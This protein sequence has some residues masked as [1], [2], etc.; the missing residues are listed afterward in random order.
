MIKIRAKNWAMN[1]RGYSHTREVQHALAAAA[2]VV[3]LMVGVSTGAA[4]FVMADALDKVKAS[5]THRA[6]CHVRDAVRHVEKERRKWE[7]G[8]LYPLGMRWFSVADMD[9]TQRAKYSATMTDREFFDLWLSL[10]APMYDK[11]RP[12]QTSLTHKYARSMA[13]HGVVE[14]EVCGQMMMAA[15]CL[16]VA[17]RVWQQSI[18]D[19]ETT[20]GLPRAELERVFGVFAPRGILAAWE[21][22]LHAFA[23]HCDD[24][25]LEPDER[26]NIE[27]G[28]EQ[29]ES[30]MVDAREY[31]AA[32]RDV[33]AT[34]TEMF[35]TTA[36]A[37]RFARNFADMGAE[38]ERIMA[39]EKTH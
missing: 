5:Q 26:R 2:G 6:H 17:D 10:G 24:F 8:L 14:A 7:H 18:T 34:L 1:P 39:E 33:S 13:A 36:D 38:C 22:L 37:R 27:L 9:A 19:S 35:A 20:T 21:R 23:P 3:K 32:G 11:T 31:F 12:W 15:S 4:L 28:L 25:D 30:T 29:L 16:V